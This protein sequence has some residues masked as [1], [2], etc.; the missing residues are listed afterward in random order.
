MQ[1]AE[2]SQ[3]KNEVWS[4]SKRISYKK[5]KKT[6]MDMAYLPDKR[7]TKLSAIHGVNY[8]VPQD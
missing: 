5:K 1:Q 3:N 2:L 6:V 8:I 4:V 7:G